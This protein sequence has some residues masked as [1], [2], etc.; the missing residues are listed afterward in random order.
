MVRGELRQIN[1][2]LKWLKDIKADEGTQLHW[3]KEIRTFAEEVYRKSRRRRPRRELIEELA[4]KLEELN[5]LCEVYRDTPH[6][7]TTLEKLAENLCRAAQ[8]IATVLHEY[9]I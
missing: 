4:M 9:T 8:R 6:S 1:I 7:N 2:H 3:A 5:V